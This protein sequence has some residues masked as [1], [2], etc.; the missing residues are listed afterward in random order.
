MHNCCMAARGAFAAL[1][2]T[3][4]SVAAA[5]GA[6]SADAFVD[7]I[8][9]NTHLSYTDTAYKNLTL[10]GK[11]SILADGH[12]VAVLVTVGRLFLVAAPS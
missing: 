2:A 12:R 7:S 8:G 9:I 4:L 11:A 10:V 3:S 5:M 6:T 1:A